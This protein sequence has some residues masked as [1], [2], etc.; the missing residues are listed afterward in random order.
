MPDDG[1][2]HE[3]QAGLLVSEPLPGARHGRI[4]IRIGYRLEDHVRRH[5][6]G[7]VVGNDSGFV[8][9]RFP[10]TVRGPDVAFLSADRQCA[11]QDE[12]RFIPGAPDLAIEVLS[13]NDRTREVLGKVSDY[14]AAGCR[15]VWVVDPE[16]RTVTAYASLLAP[17][18]HGKDDRFRAD[19]LLP[20]FE[21]RVGEI[22]D[23]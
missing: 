2:R 20:D 7:V 17:V 16:A 14:L 21:L 9:A 18:V 13:P 8:L 11:V 4:A 23:I 5:R 22:F 6:L 15:A 19:D 10:D 3:L 12:L 1:F